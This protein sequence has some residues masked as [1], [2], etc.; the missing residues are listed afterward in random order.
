[1]LHDYGVPFFPSVAVI[2]RKGVVRFTGYPE[3]KALEVLITT[4]EGESAS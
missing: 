3:E 4:L 1:M 2:D